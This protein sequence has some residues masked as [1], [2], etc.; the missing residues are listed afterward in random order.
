MTHE[1]Q[2]RY[3]NANGTCKANKQMPR[4]KCLGYDRDGMNLN[5][6]ETALKILVRDKGPVPIAIQVTK[7]FTAYNEGI[8]YDPKCGQKINH[9]VLL[10]GYGSEK[11]VDYW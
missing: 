4:V 3:Q 6:N 8:F 11:G 7:L 9:A 10:V 1:E 2:Y 5:G